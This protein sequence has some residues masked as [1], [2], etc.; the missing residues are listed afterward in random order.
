MDSTASETE[1]YTIGFAKANLLA[2]V[3][4][5]PLIA[6]ILLPYFYF[7]EF[8]TL[9]VSFLRMEWYHLLLLIPAIILHEVLHAIGWAI[10]AK[11][12]MKSVKFGFVWKFLTP[13]CHCTVP[14][15]VKHYKFG[16]ALPLIILGVIPSVAAIVTGSGILL[17]F[18]IIMTCAAGGDILSLIMLARLDNMDWVYDHPS[19]MGFVKHSES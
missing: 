3:L 5:F 17:V 18:G 13:Y 14:L 1:E 11:G 19:K 6:L 12:G 4:C 10:F 7:H 16:T 8:S 15:L 9:Q 2:I